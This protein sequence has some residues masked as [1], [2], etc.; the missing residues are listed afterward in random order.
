MRRLVTVLIFLV[1]LSVGGALFIFYFPQVWGEALF[2]YPYREMFVDAWQKQQ[3]KGCNMPRHLPVAVGYVESGHNPQAVSHAGARGIMQLVPATAVGLA[4]KR[5]LSDFKVSQLGDAQINILLGTDY[6]CSVILAAQGDFDEALARYNLGGRA[7]N[8]AL[9]PR[10][11]QGFVRKVKGVLEAYNRIYGPND[12]GPIKP[13]VVEKPKSFLSI[14]SV[15]N[16]FN[17][18]VCQ[19]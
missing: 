18:W 13:F 6:L 14:I 12:E 19:Q 16:L 2:P 11:T 17:F 8:R 7:E 1:F 5:G 4:K 3:D 15:T 10:E 9:W